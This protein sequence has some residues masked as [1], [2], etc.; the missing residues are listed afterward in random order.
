LEKIGKNWKKIVRN[1]RKKI[2]KEPYGKYIFLKYLG[3]FQA[4]H[5]LVEAPQT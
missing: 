4:R 2:K 5:I 3:F 1:E